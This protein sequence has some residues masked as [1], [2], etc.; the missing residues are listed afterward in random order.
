MEN[1]VKYK[2]NVLKAFLNPKNAYPE[3][4]FPVRSPSPLLNL[5]EEAYRKRVFQSVRPE[6]I[7]G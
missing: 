2:N 7:E 4:V 6:F 5:T 1:R 3:N